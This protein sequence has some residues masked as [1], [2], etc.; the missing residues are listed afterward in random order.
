MTRWIMNLITSTGYFGIVALM[1]VENL[2]PPIPSEF[3]MPL[4]GFMVAEGR[5]S[6]IGIIIAGTLGSVLGALALYYCGRKLGAERLKR[7]A[8][9]RGRWLTLTRGDIEK[10]DAWFDRHG[11]KAVL[12]CRL[13]PGIRSLISIPA[14]INRMN[15]LPF[16]VFTTIGAGIWTSALAYAGYLLGSNFHAV[17]EYF[18]PVSLVV[19]GLIIVLYLWRVFRNGRREPDN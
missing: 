3:I 9:R 17:E 11:A 4:A 6:L 10:A 8:D 19:F 1:F 5:L 12:L 13:I 15:L 16:L 18:D 2:F 14:G 7:F